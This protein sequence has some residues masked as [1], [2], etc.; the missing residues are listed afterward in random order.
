MT[1]FGGKTVV[2]GWPFEGNG[3][4]CGGGAV[5]QLETSDWRERTAT[6]PAAPPRKGAPE[7]RKNAVLKRGTPFFG[8]TQK[9]LIWGKLRGS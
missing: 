4:S 3:S 7:R 8:V 6:D 1:I 9:W 5:K 2:F